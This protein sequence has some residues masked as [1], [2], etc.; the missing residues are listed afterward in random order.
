[1][2]KI[3]QYVK[4]SWYIVVVILLLLFVQ[5]NCELTLPEYTSDIIDV[6]ISSKGIESAVPEAIRAS[7][8]S[9]LMLFMT[10]DEE[11]LVKEQFDLV[12]KEEASKSQLKK[13]DALTKEDIYIL[14]EDAEKETIEETLKE[15][16]TMVAFLASDQ[17]EAKKVREQMAAGMQLQS[18]DVPTF[19]QILAKMPRENRLEMKEKMLE[20]MQ[21]M[22][23]DQISLQFVSG[24]YE[25][26]GLDVDKIQFNYLRTMALKMIGLSLLGMAVAILVS[27][28]ASRVAASASRDLRRKVFK[29]VVSF[30]NSEKEAFS[31]ASLIT[32]CSNDVQQVQMII[33]MLL[34]MVALAPI[35]GIGGVIKVLQSTRSM[36]W[37]IVLAVGLILCIV[38]VLMVVAMPKFKIM[39]TMVDKLNLVARE[40]LTGIPVIRAFSREKHEESRFDVA[41]TDLMKTQLFTNRCMA[42]MMPTMMFIMNGIS[43][44]IVWVAAH[45]IDQGLIGLGDMTAFITYTMQIVMSFLILTMIS[46]MLPRAAVAADRID[47]VLKTDVLIKD[48]KET[49]CLPEAK[50]G[51]VEFHD[52]SFAYN[53]AEEDA[54][55]HI[56][57]TAKPGETTAIIGS[58]GCGKSTLLHLIPRLFD[59]TD[60]SITLDGVDIRDLTLEELRD[61]IGFVPQ[62]GMLFS[63]TIESNI[64]YANED[65]EDADMI[66]AAQI[67]QA[68][69][70]ID[71]KPEKYDTPISQGGTNVSGGQKQRLS[72]ARAIAKKPKVYIFDD[73]FSALDYKTDVTL[74]KSLKEEVKDATVIIVAQRISTILH[75]EQILVLEDGKIVGAGTHEE[76]LA[77][78]EVY[79]QI[80]E[81]QLSK[82]EIESQL[83]G[84]EAK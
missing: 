9:Q 14:K 53:N 37:I 52:V 15:C 48:K 55:E 13:Y 28:L 27:L 12:K 31:T 25:Q 34:R 60:G 6:G 79:R 69:E 49:K 44:L 70:F 50:K 78:N 81:S 29:K 54:L 21:D 46:I 62:K 72:I 30:S 84:K 51:V 36:G 64:K 7:S 26:V 56:S 33:V 8:L 68:T 40:I 59:V 61:N 38:M 19:F 47:E 82:A 39:Q 17:D 75:A 71:S 22:M 66:K 5:A 11:N 35:M 3:V 45:K 57:F 20:H 83:K 16:E 42:F 32:R 10:E 73:S 4:K 80:A 63:G 41:N 1:M 58:S 2:L 23:I 18:V 43:V 77:G 74:R 76:L 24:E 67:A 65:M